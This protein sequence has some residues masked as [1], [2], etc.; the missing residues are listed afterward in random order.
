MIENIFSY[1][2]LVRIFDK[3]LSDNDKLN[4]F[5]VSKYLFKNRTKFKFYEF[6][7]CNKKDSNKWYYDCLINIKIKEVFKFPKNLTHLSFDY[8]F[9]EPID[10]LIKYS[11]DTLTHL[12]FGHDF[13]QKIDNLIPNSIVYLEFGWNFNRSL[14]TL[15]NLPL[16]S[17]L[18]LSCHFNQSVRNCIPNSVRKIKFGSRFN[19]SIKNCIPNFV[20]SLKFGYRFDKS[21]DDL[22]DSIIFLRLP[23]HYFD[24][25]TK[26][27]SN[28]KELKVSKQF[29]ENNKNIISQ[30]I[31][32][33]ILN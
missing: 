5:T 14:K 2:F 6:Y 24:V 12:I 29:I 10:D 4:L 26:F 32:L 33:Q 17:T 31:V 22:P 11:P 30:T 15:I 21:I 18:I 3:L 7:S 23:R 1:P 25:V 9:N 28:L 20:E 16:L 19:I 27:P 8:S 13:N